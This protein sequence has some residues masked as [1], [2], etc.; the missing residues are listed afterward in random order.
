[1]LSTKN[2]FC[3]R[4][5]NVYYTKY[6][7]LDICHLCTLQQRQIQRRNVKTLW[8]VLILESI[9]FEKLLVKLSSIRY[10]QILKYPVHFK[11]I[12][13]KCT[14]IISVFDY[15]SFIFTANTLAVCLSFSETILTSK[16]CFD[17]SFVHI[18][19]YF[20]K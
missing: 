18:Y 6:K 3:V 16:A 8:T 17:V 12:C 14:C 19:L 11:S 1:M 10:H 2:M 5:T 13:I 15:S 20:L 7:Y 9:C 4:T